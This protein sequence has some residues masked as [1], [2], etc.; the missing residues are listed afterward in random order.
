[1]HKTPRAAVKAWSPI[2]HQHFWH[3]WLMDRCPTRGT[4]RVWGLNT[5]I[6][7]VQSFES[8]RC[9]HHSGIW[10]QQPASWVTRS[11][12][13]IIW[14]WKKTHSVF[15]RFIQEGTCENLVPLKEEGLYHCFHFILLGFIIYL[16]IFGDNLKWRFSLLWSIVSKIDF[17]FYFFWGG[18]VH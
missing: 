7:Q 18:G 16:Q 5:N 11:Y 17:Y 9:W 3:L 15:K 14:I 2:V 6:S 8:S 4:V 12:V 1:M 13:A 10:Q